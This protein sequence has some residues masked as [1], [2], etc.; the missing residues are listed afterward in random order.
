MRGGAGHRKDGHNAVAPFC[1][2]I[3]TAVTQQALPPDLERTEFKVVFGVS[4]NNRIDC[5]VPYVCSV[6]L[7]FEQEANLCL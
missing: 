1:P 2:E 5:T 6:R 4:D 3:L 7:Y